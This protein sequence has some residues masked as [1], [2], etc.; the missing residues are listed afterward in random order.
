MEKN[1]DQCAGD[2]N[3]RGR[4]FLETK[5]VFGTKVAEPKFLVTKYPVIV[6]TK[7]NTN[8]QPPEN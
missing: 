8:I 1:E 4:K 2:Q 6:I 3:Y 7:L 5:Y